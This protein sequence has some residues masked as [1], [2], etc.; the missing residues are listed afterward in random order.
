MVYAWLAVGATRSDA[1]SIW[2]LGDW[3]ER[4]PAPDTAARFGEFVRTQL[5]PV[6]EKV[7]GL[8]NPRAPLAVLQ[9]SM[10]SAA[11]GGARFS[12]WHCH[13]QQMLMLGQGLGVPFDYLFD[14]EIT[15]KV[16]KQ[17]KIVYL[18]WA[19]CLYEEQVQALAEASAAGT[20]VVTDAPGEWLRAHCRAFECLTNVVY[21]NPKDLSRVRPLFDWAQRTG[22]GLRPEL[23][24]WSDRDKE[25]DGSFTFVKCQGAKRY[26]IVVNAASTNATITTHVKGGRTL[27]ETYAPSEGKLF[28]F[29]G[30]CK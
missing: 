1:L 21:R 13:R 27:R 10:P 28:E 19:Y 14:G 4:P 23:F 12:A 29:E 11:A 15:A 2:N 3:Y 8:E 5:R 7:K 9:P 24:A 25:A 26:V 18:P 22:D 30:V 20:K 6:A 17:Y 16:L